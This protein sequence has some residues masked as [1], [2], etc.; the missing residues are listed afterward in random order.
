MQMQHA[1]IKVLFLT[2]HRIRIAQISSAIAACIYCNTYCTLTAYRIDFAHL[3]S[4]KT[5]RIYCGAY[6]NTLSSLKQCNSSM[7]LFATPI[8]TGCWINSAH[9]RCIYAFIVVL[10]N[11]F[12]QHT[13][14]AIAACI[15][16]DTYNKLQNWLHTYVVQYQHALTALLILTGYKN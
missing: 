5:A 14:I 10:I 16:C 12:T 8:L 11:R 13:C 15:Y 7:H 9:L 4:A 6:I 1:F 2:R 3:C